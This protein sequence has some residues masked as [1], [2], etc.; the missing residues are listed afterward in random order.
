MIENN[1]IIIVDDIKDDLEKLQSVFNQHGVGCK[2]FE[3]DGFSFPEA[4]LTGVR[5][6]F[7]D[8]NLTPGSDKNATLKEAIS[9]FISVDNGPY[10]LI[11]WSNM[12][13]QIASFKDFINRTDDDF[14]KRLKPLHVA[15]IDKLAFLE[16]SSN[17]TEKIDELF[18]SEMVQCLIRF[19]ES[20][21]T[22][23]QKTLN[24]ILEIIPFE[25]PWGESDIYNETCKTVFSKIAEISQGLAVAQERPDEA[26]KEAILPIFKQILIQNDDSYW[27]KYLEPLKQANKAAD[28]KFPDAF[29]VDKLNSVYHID[30]N[31]IGNRLN[32]ER[33]AVCAISKD[34]K[35]SIFESIFKIEFNNW[36]SLT[37]P[38]LKKQDRER[39]TIIAIEYS[40]AC[41]FSQNKKRTHKYLLGAL[42]PANCEGRIDLNRL[43]DY[44]YIFPFPFVY[45]TSSYQI[46]VNLNFTFTL[47]S[48]DQY[49]DSPIFVLSKEAMDLL[50]QRYA[51]HISRIGITYF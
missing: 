17:L 6:A 43:G 1:R 29:S 45:S 33:G 30:E 12:T 10:V 35:A 27:E 7:F 37:F 15:A 46:A 39:S 22:A 9:R 23:A 48:K 8:I 18:S 25:D 5:F 14:R 44:T 38:G 50:G 20:V 49:L 4:P 40:A 11:F 41:D 13:D 21:Q 26:V 28:L 51:N 16:P 34:K 32:T 24:R 19:D 2:C 47:D 42:L 3:Y 31:N 36:F